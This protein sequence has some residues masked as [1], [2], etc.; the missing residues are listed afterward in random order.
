MIAHL[1][2]A[3]ACDRAAGAASGL[4]RSRDGSCGT[5]IDARHRVREREE[6]RVAPAC[7]TPVLA[8]GRASGRRCHGSRHHDRAGR[9]ALVSARPRRL[10]SA[11]GRAPP[12]SRCARGRCAR[13]QDRPTRAW[14]LGDDRRLRAEPHRRRRRRVERASALPGR[15]DDEARDRRRRARSPYRDPCAGVAGLL[16][17][18]LDAH[19]LGQR[20]RERPRSLAR[21]ID[22]RGLSA[23]QRADALDRHAR[24]RDVRRLRASHPCVAHSRPRRAAARLR[25]RQ[26]HDGLGHRDA[27][28]RGL[29]RLGRPRAASRASSPASRLPTAAIC[30]GSSRTSATCRSSIAFAPATPASSSCTR[31]G[32]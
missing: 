15:V 32:G 3:A 9:A 18:L 20:V 31:P 23:C 11:L 7:G 28:P 25:L 5:W 30:S 29:A 4:V 17:S 8:A 13:P 14:L 1:S 10:R 21:R 16:A 2:A 19:A 26:A 27:P 6:A 22:E 12:R 24:L